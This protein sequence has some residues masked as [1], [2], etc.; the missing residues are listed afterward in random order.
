MV[1]AP[2]DPIWSW[3]SLYSKVKP[4]SVTYGM[5]VDQH[6]KEGRLITCE[7]DDFY[8]VTACELPPHTVRFCDCYCHCFSDVPNAGEGLKRLDYRQE[9]DKDFRAYLKNLD[10]KKPLILCGDFN[11]A[12]NEIGM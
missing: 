5:G 6:D 3:C 2:T 11:V 9:W 8:F 10:S 1:I 4:V 7:Y 12:H